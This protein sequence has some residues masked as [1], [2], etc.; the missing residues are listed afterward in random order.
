[1]SCT[2]ACLISSL[3]P[4]ARYLIEIPTSAA[5][6]ERMRRVCIIMIRTEGDGEMADV[7]GEC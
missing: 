1:M 5:R 3:A 7:L 4:Q 6:Y 2:A